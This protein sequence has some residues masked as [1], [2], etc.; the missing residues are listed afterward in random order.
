MLVYDS[1]CE[2]SVLAERE[3]D[4]TPTTRE[5]STTHIRTMGQIVM[6][7]TLKHFIH[8]RVALAH[9]AFITH[10]HEKESA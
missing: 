1:K 10:W 5:T 4:R 8:D 9:C 7:E 3:S 2:F 6:P